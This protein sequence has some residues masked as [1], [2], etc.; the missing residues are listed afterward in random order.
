MTLLTNGW[1]IVCPDDRVRHYPYHNYDDAKC[2]AK[3]YS[4]RQ[5]ADYFEEPSPLELAQPKCPEGIHT[6]R[7][8]AF[9]PPQP[10]GEA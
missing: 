10:I 1:E 3:I 5:C 8:I 4:E 2:D 6:V 7:P 9:R